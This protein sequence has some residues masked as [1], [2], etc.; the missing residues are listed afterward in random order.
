MTEK[1]ESELA[2]RPAQREF[3]GLTMEVDK[4]D[5]VAIAASKYEEQLETAKSSLSQKLEELNRLIKDG[6]ESIK[7]DCELIPRQ[8][9]SSADRELAKALRQAGY[10][11]FEVAVELN[12]IEEAGQQVS[13]TIRLVPKSDRYVR[14]I[15]REVKAPFAPS[16]RQTLKD[17]KAARISAAA[18][19]SRLAE[20]HRKL[21][22]V[23]QV[24]RKARARLAQAALSRSSEGQALLEQ[25]SKVGETSLPQFLL[26]SR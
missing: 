19:H 14:D 3:L 10:G 11:S 23:P 20:I 1:N 22:N 6:E 8:F 2:V 7:K 24:E 15:S 4:G 13:L 18:V 26:E 16:I 9:D 25:I 17:L 5:I 12:Q 21:A